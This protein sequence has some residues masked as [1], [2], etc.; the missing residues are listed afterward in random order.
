MDAK[1]NGAAKPEGVKYMP[2]V[3]VRP[4]RPDDVDAI[5]TVIAGAR[6]FLGSQNIDQWQGNYPD[7]A[8]V[9][10]DIQNQANRVLVVDGRVVG[11]ASLIQGPDPFY[12]YIEGGS[13]IGGADVPY[14]AIHRFAIG[15]AG[16][17]LHLSRAFLT[18]LLSELY[19]RGVRDVRID[20]HPDNKIMQ[21][22]VL[23]NGFEHRGLVYLDEPVPERL[24]YQLVFGGAT[25]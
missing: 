15:D 24:A 11:I 8:A 22:V 13:W 7:R 2:A 19:S 6:A 10:L 4:G 23:S 1:R 12:K 5:M 3:F 9:E 25:E 21:H 16:R 18:A 17:G 14:Y 20:T